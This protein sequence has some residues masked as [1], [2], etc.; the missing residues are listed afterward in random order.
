MSNS[1]QVT[2]TYTAV[3]MS[4][5]SRYYALA[6]TASELPQLKLAMYADLQAMLESQNSNSS[7]CCDPSLREGDAAATS[8]SPLC[9]C[10]GNFSVTDVRT[11]FLGYPELLGITFTVQ[12]VLTGSTLK[13]VFPDAVD[14]GPDAAAAAAVPS[15]TEYAAAAAPLASGSYAADA[16]WSAT[17]GVRVVADGGAG[18]SA[19]A[20][21]T[22]GGTV[23]GISSPPGMPFVF[24]IAASD[25][26]PRVR[27]RVLWELTRQSYM[28]AYTR[29][30]NI[31]THVTLDDVA[32]M[33]AMKSVSMTRSSVS[34]LSAGERSAAAAA[35]AAAVRS[36]KPLAVAHNVD[37]C[38]V[39][40]QSA[41]AL[42]EA[43]GSTAANPPVPM[44]TD[45]NRSYPSAVV[46]TAQDSYTFTLVAKCD[47]A[48]CGVG[49][50]CGAV[51]L[52]LVLGAALA[53][54]HQRWRR[55]REERADE[56]R[57]LQRQLR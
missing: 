45:G 27:E 53:Y 16:N 29:D 7:V 37:F 48:T 30:V 1:E 50:V 56:R 32:A 24:T 17:P 54:A 57:L 15:A 25:A 3:L 22:M 41:A 11:Q 19:A 35:A 6:P 4:K 36:A 43:G 18:A 34:S 5:A 33:L 28:S 20:T 38:R 39:L 46:A 8:T 31:F 13:L 52:V 9:V 10:I 49:I 12:F 2:C 55:A 40:R 44:A 14:A 47:G 21:A 26:F 51:M 42:I 23:G